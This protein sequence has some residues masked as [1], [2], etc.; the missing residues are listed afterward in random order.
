MATFFTFRPIYTSSYQMSCLTRYF[1]ALLIFTGYPSQDDGRERAGSK[2]SSWTKKTM[3]VL[4]PSPQGL[5]NS[6]QWN[7]WSKRFVQPLALASFITAWSISMLVTKFLQVMISH[8]KS[9]CLQK[10]QRNDHK[11][12]LTLCSWHCE[13]ERLHQQTQN[14]QTLLW[15][16]GQCQ[17]TSNQ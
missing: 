17:N 8:F 6:Q 12:K 2:R 13:L 14:H 10:P 3:N 16:Q 1:W 7:V 5:F 15:A 4:S 9:P 11:T